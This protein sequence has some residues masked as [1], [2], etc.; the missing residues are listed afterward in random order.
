MNVE[1]FSV[2][3]GVSITYAMTVG[4]DEASDDS[5][6]EPDADHTKTSICPGVSTMMWSVVGFAG[7]SSPSAGAFGRQRF[8][9]MLMTWSIFVLK[10]FRL[11]RMPP[12]G[13]RLYCF[14]TSL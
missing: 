2:V 8:S 4:K 7:V 10:R 5:R 11:V 6:M 13:P 12:F 9:R 3:R 14:M 1:V